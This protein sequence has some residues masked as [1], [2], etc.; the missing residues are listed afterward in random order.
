MNTVRQVP[1]AIEEPSTKIKPKFESLQLQSNPLK[2]ASV[3][4]TKAVQPKD[5][6]EAFPSMYFA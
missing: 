4:I 3:I 2:Y 5:V 1:L 6:I